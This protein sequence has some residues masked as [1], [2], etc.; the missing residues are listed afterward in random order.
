MV[1]IVDTIPSSRPAPIAE[2]LSFG[3]SILMS[4]TSMFSAAK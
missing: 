1:S 4:W 3:S 2:K